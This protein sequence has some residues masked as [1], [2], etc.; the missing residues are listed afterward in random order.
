VDGITNVINFDFPQ[1]TEDY[2]HRI[3]RTGRSDK[4]GTAYT[5]FTL[6][7]SKQAADLVNVLEEAN[8]QIPDQLLNWSR[9]FGG[10]RGGGGGGGGGRFRNGG[11]FKKN[12]NFGRGGGGGSN[13]FDQAS[14]NGGYGGGGQSN[15]RIVFDDND[16]HQSSSN[17]YKRS[18]KPSSNGYNGQ[19]KFSN[20][21]SHDMRKKRRFD[22]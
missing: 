4:K 19:S 21:D 15:K 1:L 10:G 17:G 3:G 6:N 14:S 13:R 22:D 16:H 11:T 9:R 7:N 8:Q 2:I 20:G 5:F 18:D 12:D